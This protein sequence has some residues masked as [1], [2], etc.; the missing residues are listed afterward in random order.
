[1]RERAQGVWER[2]FSFADV[3]TRRRAERELPK[4]Q[5][6][7]HWFGTRPRRHVGSSGGRGSPPRWAPDLRVRRAPP[8]KPADGRFEPTASDGSTLL[9]KE[10]AWTAIACRSV[11]A[12]PSARRTGL[13]LIVGGVHHWWDRPRHGRVR[14]L[15]R[16]DFSGS[17]RTSAHGSRAEV[18]HRVRPP[19]LIQ[20]ASA[21][22]YGTPRAPM[23]GTSVYRTASGMIFRV[24]QSGETIA[25]SSALTSS[26]WVKA[27]PGIVGLRV[28]PDTIRLTAR[29]VLA[30][31]SSY[32]QSAATAR[33]ATASPGA[34]GRS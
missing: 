22:R 16:P 1:M 20:P 25:R 5:S 2:S 14:D 4:T 17:S 28:A 6:A 21:K 11:Y 23:S 32:L 13:D 8:E 26:A 30:L 3:V 31:P 9:G 29:Q 12:F 18:R 27:Q 15:S 7:P 24:S 10:V 19:V 34:S 33:A